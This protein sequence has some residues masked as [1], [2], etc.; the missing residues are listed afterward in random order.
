MTT[1]RK[2]LIVEPLKLE[3]SEFKLVDEFPGIDIRYKIQ[4]VM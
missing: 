2:S 3:M 4:C 1:S